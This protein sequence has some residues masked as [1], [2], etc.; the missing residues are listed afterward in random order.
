MIVTGAEEDD[1]E[2]LKLVR[3]QGLTVIVKGTDNGAMAG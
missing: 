2:V 3:T 1:A